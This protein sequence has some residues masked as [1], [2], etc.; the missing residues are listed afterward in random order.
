MKLPRIFG[1]D[2]MPAALIAAADAAKHGGGDWQWV[3][4]AQGYGRGVGA[5]ADS[6]TAAVEIIDVECLRVRRKGVSSF[7]RMCPR[8]GR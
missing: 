7:S 4:L 6:A 1:L 2:R 5:V 8:S 3:K